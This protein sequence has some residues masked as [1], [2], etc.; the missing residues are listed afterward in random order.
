M[1]PI[2]FRRAVIREW[3]RELLTGGARFTLAMEDDPAQHRWAVCFIVPQPRARLGR[4][5]WDDQSLG[6]C[7]RLECLHILD[8]SGERRSIFDRF[9]IVAHRLLTDM[10]RLF[11]WI[12]RFADVCRWVVAHKVHTTTIAMAEPSASREVLIASKTGGPQCAQLRHGR[13]LRNFRRW[14]K[15]ITLDCHVAALPN[16][17]RTITKEHTDDAQ[18]SCL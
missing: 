11:L 7:Q 12:R 15:R 5:R 2:A 3:R 10:R 17:C 9:S 6:T 4:R 14:V 8:V 16:R 13:I 18:A 1:C